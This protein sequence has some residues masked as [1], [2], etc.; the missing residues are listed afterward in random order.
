M[1]FDVYVC[2]PDGVRSPTDDGFAANYTSNMGAFFAWAL[3]GVETLDPAARCDSRDALFGT[4]PTDGLKAL[5]GLT[6]PAAAE[7]LRKALDRI[8]ATPSHELTKFDAPNGWGRHDRAAEFLRKICRACVNDP[9][10]FV[11]VS[12]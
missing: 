10:A 6:A 2:R 4:P 9:Q 5:D 11:R 12:W 7:R 8:E 1:S 3:D